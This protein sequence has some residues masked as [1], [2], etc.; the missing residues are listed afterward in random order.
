MVT[1]QKDKQD[2]RQ[3][4]LIPVVERAEQQLRV[5]LKQV[6]HEVANQVSQAEKQAEEHVEE[7]WHSISELVEQ[8][9]KDKLVELQEQAEQISRSSEKH[10]AHL[11]QKAKKNMALAVQRVVEAVIGAPYEPTAVGEQT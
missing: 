10:R 3:T 11:Q 4:S 8:R 6:R 7:S 5:E 9:R 1:K 2:G